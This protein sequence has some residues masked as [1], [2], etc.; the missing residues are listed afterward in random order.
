[1]SS[2]RPNRREAQPIGRKSRRRRKLGF[3]PRTAPLVVEPLEDRMV[4]ALDASFASGA[5][6][7]VSDVDQ[8]ITVSLVSTLQG[9]QT[10]YEVKVNGVNP[11]RSGGGVTLAT[12]VTGISVTDSDF[13]NKINL[14]AVRAD[15]FVNIPSSSVVTIHAGGGNDTVWGTAF[16]DS[17]LAGDGDDTIDASYG[18]DTVFG[19]EGNDRLKT[20]DFTDGG[21][22]HGDDS[23][24][25]GGGND[26]ID[27]GEGSDTIVGEGGADSLD[28]G[29]GDDG[30]DFDVLLGGV[31]N[32]SLKDNTGRGILVGGDGNDSVTGDGGEGG[33]VIGG[34]GA[35]QIVG[36]SADDLLVDGRTPFDGTTV[37]IPALQRILAEWQSGRPYDLRSL[38][39]VTTGTGGLNQPYFLAIESMQDDGD[40]DTLTGGGGVDLFLREAANNVI[41]DHQANEWIGSDRTIPAATDD[42]IFAI[43]TGSTSV[44]P[45]SSLLANDSDGS[46]GTPTINSPVTALV[47]GA[48]LST[49]RT[50]VTIDWTNVPAGQPARFQYS[51]SSGSMN[52]IRSATVSVYRTTNSSSLF[53]GDFKDDPSDVR[54]VVTFNPGA[55][56]IFLTPNKS[57]SS[58]SWATLDSSIA[59]LEPMRG[60]FNADGRPDIVARHGTTGEWRVWTSTGTT[61]AG[62]GSWGKLNIAGKWSNSITGDFDGDGKDDLF[63]FD[64]QTADFVVSRST[65]SAFVTSAWGNAYSLLSP[66]LSSGIQIGTEVA[67][68]DGNGK[69]DVLVYDAASSQWAFVLSEGVRFAELTVPTSFPDWS[70]HYVGDFDKDGISDL[71][72][73]NSTTGRWEKANFTASGFAGNTVPY[74]NT[75]VGGA[76]YTV[77]D[78][79]NDGRDDLYK[80]A[81]G[82]SWYI[83]LGTPNGL[84]RVD[85]SPWNS[86]S[87]AWKNHFNNN[88][89]AH[90]TAGDILDQ[91]FN[92]PVDVDTDQDGLFDGYEQH[93]ILTGY[94]DF[95]SDDDG[96]GD[97]D[98]TFLSN[99]RP[100][101]ANSDGGEGSSDDLNDFVE[102]V[103]RMSPNDPA[104]GDNNDDFDGDGVTNYDEIY[105]YFTNP[106]SIDS[107]GDGLFDKIEL[108]AGFDPW[109]KDDLSLDHDGD[110]LSTQVEIARTAPTSPG[111]SDSDNDGL[112]DGAEVSQYFT[113]PLTANTDGDYFDDLIEVRFGMNPVS[114]VLGGS[115]DDF[116]G[117]GLSN[118]T[119]IYSS[120]TDPAAADS[121]GDGINDLIEKDAGFDP[122]FADDVNLD[123]DGDGLTTLQE[124]SLPT[125]TNPGRVDTNNNGKSDGLDAVLAGWITTLTFDAMDTDGDGLTD[126]QETAAGTSSSWPDSD[127]DGLADGLEIEIGSNPLS[128]NSDQIVGGQST[129]DANFPDAVEYRLGF[130]PALVDMGSDPDDDGILSKD[131][132]IYISYW[133]GY[134]IRGNPFL[135]DSNDD[136]VGDNAYPSTDNFTRLLVTWEDLDGDGLS[137]AQEAAANTNPAKPD[138]DGDGLSDGLEVS[139][140][141]NPKN[142]DSDGIVD[143][144]ATTDQYVNDAVEYRLGFDPAKVDLNTDIDNDGV[145]SHLELRS[146]N[147]NRIR[148]NPNLADTDGDSVDDGEELN[149]SF[150]FAP[151][152]NT[153]PYLGGASTA[154]PKPE[155]SLTPDVTVAENVSTG[156]VQVQLRLTRAVNQ[157]FRVQLA[158]EDRGAGAGQDYQTGL[159][160]VEF[161]PSVTSMTVDI[162][163]INNAVAEEDERFLVKIVSVSLPSKIQLDRTETVVTISDDDTSPPGTS[164]DAD[165][166][167]GVATGSENTQ[168]GNVVQVPI[169]LSQPL[170]YDLRVYLAY[171][172]Q[173]ATQGSDYNVGPSSVVIPAGQST[174]L[175]PVPII[176]NA[177]AEPAETFQVRITS[178]QTIGAAPPSSG[179]VRVTSDR[180]TATIL[181]NDIAPVNPPN[182]RLVAATATEGPSAQL[183][184]KVTLSEPLQSNLVVHLSYASQTAV[185]G[186]DFNAGP[187]QVTLLAGTLS[188]DVSIPLIDNTLFESTETF[189]VSVQ[190]VSQPSAV[191]IVQSSAQG[192]I[193]DNDLTDYEPVVVSLELKTDDGASAVD[194]VTSNP[195]V[196]IE[197]LNDDGYADVVVQFDFNGDGTPDATATPATD[198][199]L[200]YY[201]SHA[202]PG[203]VTLLVR[204]MEG[205]G[206]SQ[207]I[208]QWASLQFTLEETTAQTPF[209]GALGSF[210]GSRI[211]A[212]HYD[213]GAAGVAYY[214]LTP[215]NT[216]GSSYRADGVDL[217]ATSDTDGSFDVT[218]LQP[219]EWMEY[220][221]TVNPG[222]F[223]GQIRYASTSAVQLE[224]E[225][226]GVRVATVSL[227][228]TGSDTTYATVSTGSFMVA[229]VTTSARIFRVRS[230]GSN[231][232]ALSLNWFSFTRTADAPN[233]NFSQMVIPSTAAGPTRDVHASV[234]AQLPTS[235]S[236][237]I[238]LIARR[239]TG[240]GGY[241]YLATV[242][243]VVSGGQTAY[244]LELWRQNAGTWTRVI[245]PSGEPARYAVT[246]GSGLLELTVLGSTL[247]VRYD[248][249]GSAI[250]ERTL[251]D[252]SITGAGDAGVIGSTS[253]YLDP[254]V[255][256]LRRIASV[257]L[258][259]DTG[260]ADGITTNPTIQGVVSGANPLATLVEYDLT[261]D[262]LNEGVVQADATGAFRFR[263]PVFATSEVSLR[264]RTRVW[265]TV[266]NTYRYG[267]W[268][269]FEFEYVVPVVAPK[270]ASL[271]LQTDSG[272]S[273]TDRITLDPTLTGTVTVAGALA[274][275]QRVEFD[276]NHDQIVDG[277]ATTDANGHF[278]FSPA[279]LTAGDHRVH[280]RA[281]SPNADGSHSF[282]SW[283]KFDF[284]LE[285]TNTP[286]RIVELALV[287]DTGTGSGA[288]SD[289]R[290]SDP[291]IT[292]RILTAGSVSGV[293]IELDLDRDGDVDTSVTTGGNGAFVYDPGTS[294]P[295][296]NYW[297]SARAVR[298]GQ[299]GPW[300]SIIFVYTLS[301]NPI[302]PYTAES[303]FNGQL[304]QARNALQTAIAAANSAFQQ[305]M[306]NAQ[307]LF[308]TE[309][310]DAI[311]DRDS[312]ETS[313][314]AAYSTAFTQA[315]TTFTTQL[316]AAQAALA[317]AGGSTTAGLEELFVWPSAPNSLTTR[318][319]RPN[320]VTPLTFS[321]EVSPV[322]TYS[323]SSQAE[324]AYNSAL[325]T[326]DQVRRQEKQN[327]DNDYNA[328]ANTARQTRDSALQAV[329]HTPPD[330]SQE[331]TDASNAYNS[332]VQSI[333]D[334]LNDSLRSSNDTY[335]SATRSAYDTYHSTV[336]DASES[337][338]S[339]MESINKITDYETRRKRA[340]EAWATYS[341]KTTNA[342]YELNQA[343]N[344]AYAAYRKR[345]EDAYAARA[346]AVIA[347]YKTLEQAYA[348][349]DYDTT[350][351]RANADRAT[352]VDKATI[353]NNYQKQLLLLEKTRSLRKAEADRVYELAKAVATKDRAYGIAAAIRT[354]RQALAGNPSNRY[355]ASLA[356]AE[357]AMA[358]AIADA[359]LARA[360]IRIQAEFSDNSGTFAAAYTRD[361]TIK[362]A[363][364]DRQIDTANAHRDYNVAR[365][366]ADKTRRLAGSNT[367]ASTQTSYVDI[368]NE[369]AK[370][371]IDTDASE[372]SDRNKAS[373]DYS[374]EQ[375]DNW[376][377]YQKSNLSQSAWERYVEASRKASEKYSKKTNEI[378]LKHTLERL[379]NG[380]SVNHTFVDT[381]ADYRST[382]AGYDRDYRDAVTTAYAAAE[383][384]LATA[385]RT[386][387]VAEAT[388]IATFKGTDADLARIAVETIEDNDTSD[389][390]KSLALRNWEQSQADEFRDFVIDVMATHVSAVQ[391]WSV[392]KDPLWASYQTALAQIDQYEQV[393]RAGAIRLSLLGKAGVEH[394]I[395]LEQYAAA[396]VLEKSMATA[397]DH[398][399]TQR[400]NADRDRAI[401]RA[402]SALAF[403]VTASA[404]DTA[405]DLAVSAADLEWTRT[406]IEA[407][408]QASHKDID[409]YFEWQKTVAKINHDRDS[410]W[411]EKYQQSQAASKKRNDESADIWRDYDRAM[412]TADAT[413]WQAV[414]DVRI[415][416]A[417]ALVDARADAS[418]AR[419]Q[420]DLAWETS[421]ADSRRDR[422]E[423]DATG[424]WELSQSFIDFNGDDADALAEYEATQGANIASIEAEASRRAME[425]LG[426]Y[427]VSIWNSHVTALQATAQQTN[428]TT[429]IHKAQT[430]AAMRDWI[431]SVSVARNNLATAI[432][433]ADSNIT[434]LNEVHSARAQHVSSQAAVEGYYENKAAEEDQELALSFANAE[435]DRT[436]GRVT[437]QLNLEKTQVDALATYEAARIS[438]D[439]A[440]EKTASQAQQ[441]YAHA[442][443]DAYNA[444]RKGSMTYEEY[445]QAQKEAREQLNAALAAANVTRV[446]AYGSAYV[447]HV[448]SIA[449]GDVDLAE[450]LGTA[451]ID[452]AVSER[453]TAQNLSNFD[454]FDA[455]AS[456]FRHLFE[457]SYRQ[458]VDT[459]VATRDGL[460]TGAEATYLSAVNTADRAILGAMADADVNYFVNDLTSRIA[461]LDSSSSAASREQARLLTIQKTWIENLRTEY[462]SF[463]Q[464]AADAD[465]ASDNGVLGS[466][467]S[468]ESSMLSNSNTFTSRVFAANTEFNVGSDVNTLALSRAENVAEKD[469]DVAV[470]NAQKISLVQHAMAGR[471]MAVELAEARRDY[472]VGVAREQAKQTFLNGN[473][474]AYSQAVEQLQNAR[475]EREAAS[476]RDFTEEKAGIFYSYVET[477]ANADYAYIS[478]T[479][480]LEFDFSV[481]RMNDARD[482]GTNVANAT[483][484]RIS[485][486]DADTIL[487][488]RID[489]WT[490]NNTTNTSWVSGRNAEPVQFARDAAQE[491]V[492]VLSNFSTYLGSVPQITSLVHE[493]TSQPQNPI[494]RG[495]VTN[496]GG[497]DGLIVEFD[498]NGDGVYEGAAPVKSDGSFVY[499]VLGLSTA[500]PSITARVREAL[501]SSSQYSS[502]AQLSFSYTVPTG[503]TPYVTQL[504]LTQDTGVVGDLRTSNPSISGTIDGS[505]IAN[506]TIQIDK[507]GNGTWDETVTTNSSGQFSYTPPGLSNGFHEIRVKPADSTSTSAISFY[508]SPT[509]DVVTGSWLVSQKYVAQAKADFAQAAIASSANH[510]STAVA[511][512]NTYSNTTL[513]AYESME[514][515]F[516][517]ADKIY[518]QAAANL[519]RTMQYAQAQAS[520][521]Y[522]LD[523]GA[524]ETSYKIHYAEVEKA[525]QLKLAEAEYQRDIGNSSAYS[526]LVQSAQSARDNALKQ[527]QRS[528]G[529]DVGEAWIDRASAM[530]AAA[531]TMVTSDS[532][533][534]NTRLQTVTSLAKQFAD[535]EAGAWMTRNQ[536]LS[537]ADGTYVSSQYSS[538][539]SELQAEANARPSDPYL[540]YALAKT[541]AEGNRS[542]SVSSTA[543]THA[544]ALESADGTTRLAMHADAVT[545]ILA[546]G[547][548]AGIQA[549]EIATQMQ[550][551]TMAAAQQVLRLGAE[552]NNTP[553]FLAPSDG[554]DPVYL[555]SLA[556][557]S[558]VGNWSGSGMGYGSF[559]GRFGWGRSYSW[560]WGWGS[561]LYWGSG[562]YYGNYGY[563]GYYGWGYPGYY[564]N[565]YGYGYGYGYGL[566]SIDTRY[567]YGY[568]LY[569][570]SYAYYGSSL[571]SGYASNFDRSFNGLL[572]SSRSLADQ[573]IDSLTDLRNVAEATNFVAKTSSRTFDSMI[574]SNFNPTDVLSSAITDDRGN[575]S[576]LNSLINTSLN[577]L[578]G[579]TTTDFVADTDVRD[580]STSQIAADGAPVHIAA[581][582]N[583]PKVE[584]L[585]QVPNL[586]SRDPDIPQPEPRGEDVAGDPVDLQKIPVDRVKKMEA[587]GL[588]KRTQGSPLAWN[589]KGEWVYAVGNMAP[590][591]AASVIVLEEYTNTTLFFFG[592]HAKYFRAVH[593]QVFQFHFDG[594]FELYENVREALE[595]GNLRDRGAGEYFYQKNQ[596]WFSPELVEGVLTF[597]LHAVPFGAAIDYG[598]QGNYWEMGMALVGDAATILTGGSAALLRSGCQIGIRAGT[599]AAKAAVIATRASRAVEIGEGGIALGTAAYQSYAGQYG[600]AA[601]SMGEAML[602]LMGVSTQLAKRLVKPGCFVAGTRI[603]VPL[604]SS[605]IIT[606]AHPNE[607]ILSLA[608]G[609]ASLGMTG[610]ILISRPRSSPTR[611]R[612]KNVLDLPEDH[613]FAG[614]DDFWM[615]QAPA[616]EDAFDNVDLELLA[617]DHCRALEMESGLEGAVLLQANGESDPEDLLPPTQVAGA[618]VVMSV[619][620]EVP[621]RRSA[622]SVFQPLMAAGWLALCLTV[623]GVLAV[624]GL[625]TKKETNAT[626]LRVLPVALGTH[627]Q[628]ATRPIEKIRVGD[629]VL[630]DE[631]FGDRDATFGDDVDP[632]SWKQLDLCVSKRN[633][634]IAEVT[635]LRP[636][637][638]VIEQGAVVGEEFPI[639]L[640]DAAIEGTAQVLE[641]TPCPPIS[642]EEGRIVTGRFKHY[643][644]TVV[645]VH[646]EGASQSITATPNHPFWSVNRQ[647]FVRADE[648]RVGEELASLSGATYA[649]ESV[650]E[651]EESATVY[652]LEVQFDHVYFVGP[653]GVLAHNAC[654]IAD[655]VSKVNGRYPINAKWAGKTYRNS[656]FDQPPLSDVDA[657]KNGVPF[658]ANGYPDFSAF[659]RNNVPGKKGEVKIILSGS[660]RED[661]AR[662]NKLAGYTTT[663]LNYTWH[664]HEDVGI[665]QLIP[666][667]IHDAVR[668][669]G[670]VAAWV[671]AK[672]VKY[673]P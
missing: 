322:S 141:S 647:E 58:T 415:T 92:S 499:T 328:A 77:R 2:S 270:L 128:N 273:T 604:E 11:A 360:Q 650:E 526:S 230:A 256:P 285:S 530:T 201:L 664:H 21:E 354:S 1:M 151:V 215:T 115:G 625:G 44:L 138:D 238:G 494:V 320:Q 418:T 112:S 324:A 225:I 373:K 594:N 509:P 559:S 656:K 506:K 7:I 580:V 303:N 88:V 168:S 493:N 75:A 97:G 575:P 10:V 50:T 525:Y 143:S 361:V 549:L 46:G 671:E 149:H 301:P 9:S 297:Y 504:S 120:F 649:V 371:M 631:T 477:V 32:D 323:Y 398:H 33:M 665:M 413:L 105:V 199:T 315:Q 519:D 279:G 385:E 629:R 177:T 512:Q 339:A 169:L 641:I 276:L 175:V 334:T 147:K 26:T 133:G 29:E 198:G 591:D 159:I 154:P 598:L 294:I 191:N 69:D 318:P 450:A 214:D 226:D 193:L 247:V 472:E 632:A 573:G 446:E 382:V 423:S 200:D 389:A 185:A 612:R 568:G 484:Q 514:T 98:E 82:D 430:A 581:G 532:A 278:V 363:T 20:K 213:A 209:G 479:A 474:Q 399:D 118:W 157:T 584:P 350:V 174:Y 393:E 508:L 286:P 220:S 388:A 224:L 140:G 84:L 436:V 670:G 210:A 187:A 490:Q 163:I 467:Q 601:G 461:G 543:L 597:A 18:N 236:A 340:A 644:A 203:E 60:D 390:S 433:N 73:Y 305:A 206:G 68:F 80:R 239:T 544:N 103:F 401:A 527:V 304:N 427:E 188:A 311:D 132:L 648:L 531:I 414:Q 48:T 627:P 378:S 485:G 546:S 536:A 195:T 271:G 643:G 38:N 402:N 587:D 91:S 660:R 275:G 407:S 144:V 107:D 428:S 106:G 445:N 242:S 516:A 603:W 440:F 553:A 227:P 62:G 204:A 116:D 186:Q 366:G 622:R 93:T 422:L 81:T 260:A 150:T 130:H 510:V 652:N 432:R 459:A 606:V 511:A 539:L 387:L 145:L 240:S 633:G 164:P 563:S 96:L 452:F 83:F 218:S 85:R 396:K 101:L 232:G 455:L 290:T 42:N 456:T 172:S 488:N 435:Y 672:G 8:D 620:P 139:I 104:R 67:D 346:R 158:Y 64:L 496:D 586:D 534:W 419:L 37:N 470:A 442:L 541:T 523:A 216:G 659:V 49:D 667:A 462:R 554:H 70:A 124:L 655:T 558:A 179:V 613:F 449:E 266:R 280:V 408:S 600:Q 31:G 642:A 646:V 90:A 19:G 668:H 321:T 136:G 409:S 545:Q 571:G 444:Y 308:F 540:Q 443:N 344:S 341:R 94:Q 623:A 515:A 298:G 78:L 517:Q 621:S 148:S 41:T 295:V 183:V 602:R 167:I 66:Y 431:S 27:G 475:R 219:T 491:A 4:F 192:T 111:K 178:T 617:V 100:D 300:S 348:N 194:R 28:G 65:G 292:G 202:S 309:S 630:S 362:D 23:L 381:N 645:D 364:K 663:P 628:H 476:R 669:S 502:T 293:T 173:T 478:A 95:D 483:A 326:A 469:R 564:G 217:R 342:S 359:E 437:G 537:T 52:S 482:Q 296:G 608:A 34:L 180:A 282:T 471:D 376:L 497:F 184:M 593:S 343:T 13:A 503:T 208:G 248:A 489:R 47:G 291:R 197:V 146:T 372:S 547:V 615:E 156:K 533:N 661:F 410:T 108:D 329:N 51:V 16:A 336:R 498:H 551:Y 57:T 463:R 657:W 355:H 333:N 500:S 74:G 370:G 129:S 312:A 513:S 161:Q 338:S 405:E 619:S 289:Y 89:W 574:N 658:K 330:Y 495:Q 254:R 524:A 505:S 259:E 480:Q 356:D 576:L 412:I 249:G 302:D 486:A 465:A 53:V 353:E 319:T 283:T 325:N 102:V 365:A 229:G 272:S 618:P 61:F 331:R 570:S 314:N 277:F 638:W 411:Q 313:A 451:E 39:I 529:V 182:L 351:G 205:T 521:R 15:R 639:N 212:E 397:I 552:G 368:Q 22:G 264:L 160:E 590:E 550:T 375:I 274:S 231:S 626:A 170:S 122:W 577:R 609:T 538:L 76:G 595:H 241:A 395:R 421:Y 439:A 357:Y 429:D 518:E 487:S 460:L 166:S 369:H 561:Y 59:W 223:N 528:F 468:F 56:G 458:S 567:L 71:I 457:S 377:S 666:T 40:V 110:G 114:S 610:A 196:A 261:G 404:A 352:I 589:P 72:G 222:Q 520:R 651:R 131:E 654:L 3:V 99:T 135:A 616:D 126:A 548:N 367:S 384:S 327:A 585:Q 262:G 349:I 611:K 14:S 662:A 109:V 383:V 237:T 417:L 207:I 624:S 653:E 36:G 234:R 127:N 257:S 121:D 562:Y 332:A 317:N 557:V 565:G 221:V 434:V 635:L 583:A 253:H 560:G 86:E 45:V 268:T 464:D 403:A 263:V 123:H 425:A 258:V 55:G 54:D 614:D 347:A 152:L 119:E 473:Y 171:D 142:I 607:G 640:P 255:L 87:T 288:S 281:G 246:N 251:N 596:S 572:S 637:T 358:T 578:E 337:Y 155:L 335:N 211:E 162:P 673:K 117:D 392:G 556:G 284:V 447:A 250:L 310:E 244:V 134:R 267:E 299:S 605:P 24:V 269:S 190:S 345:N 420:A 599:A 448:T 569:G 566:G 287:A 265:D 35:D 316:A 306:T 228:S 307:N 12:E 535:T 522:A 416:K 63:S 113:N 555:S 252:G 588:A 17:I 391:S 233:V 400:A 592:D 441:V 481:A 579:S 386:Y 424:R 454:T 466:Q 153:V 165:L 176:D 79:N 181:D 25:G 374:L 582:V 492:N 137:A 634:S 43:V 406:E 426:N 636:D 501:G 394:T 235:A 5:L 245:D 380:Q 542:S 379:D 189:Q 125:P 507:D 30:Y 438:A 6:T 453:E 243:S